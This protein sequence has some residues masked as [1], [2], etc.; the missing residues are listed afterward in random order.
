MEE[1]CAEEKKE[2]GERQEPTAESFKRHRR[3]EEEA[4]D[5]GCD[6]KGAD[7]R[8]LGELGQG[9]EGACAEDDHDGDL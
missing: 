4:E 8:D 2:T 9:Q 3:K 1:I 5:D 6:G 7:K